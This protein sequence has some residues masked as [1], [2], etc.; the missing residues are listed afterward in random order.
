MNLLTATR[1]TSLV[2]R[3]TPT[4]SLLSLALSAAGTSS[5]APGRAWEAPYAQ[6]APTTS[7]EPLVASAPVGALRPSE[8]TREAIATLRQLSGLTW[9]QLATLFG[10]SRRSVHFWASG[11][12]LSAAHEE[13]LMQALDVVRAADRGDARSNRAALLDVRDGVSALSLLQEGRFE[14]V[15]ALLG[16]G[17]GR[18]QPVQK[19]LS[20]EAKAARAPLPLETLVEAR[21][22]RVHQDPPGARAARAVGSGQRGTP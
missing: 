15:R 16:R 18:H 12:P 9:E 11:E 4:W 8:A 10:V 22:E 7:G 19:P 1:E 14:E 13:Q 2:S 17:P 5:T 6:A 3:Y 20:L 21:H